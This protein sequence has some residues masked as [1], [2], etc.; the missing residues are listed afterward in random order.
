MNA[1]SGEPIRVLHVDDETDFAELTAAFLER[2]DAAF[3]VETAG[4]ADEAER[5]LAARPFD[6]VVSDYDMPGEN[7]IEFL[8]SVREEHPDLPFVLFTGKGSE[9]VA[10]DAIS[11]GVTDYL[12]KERGTDQ[13]A[14]LAN[15]IAN[16]VEHHR[17]R[18]MVE[19]SE[20]RL[21]EI[22]DTLPDVLYVVDEDGKYL[23]AN[24]VLAEFHD[25]DV[26]EIEGATVEDVLGEDAERFVEDL[27][28]TL[29]ADGVRRI[30]EVTVTDRAGE[31]HVFESRLRPYDPGDGGRAVLGVATDVTE[32]KERE[33]EIERVRERMELA[34]DHTESVIFEVDLDTG[35]VT[36]HGTYDTFFEQSPEVLPTWEDHCE[37]VVHPDDRE[38]FRRLHRR[39]I[40]GET[41][42]EQIEYRTNP[43]TG[44][45]RWISAHL[46]AVAESGGR[47]RALGISRDVTERK[48]REEELRRIERRYGAIFDD[49]NIL[50]GLTD[51]DGTL[52]K[53]NETAMG[54]VDAAR[55]EVVGTPFWETPWFDHSAAARVREGIGRAAA[56]EYVAFE[57]DLVRSGGDPYTVSGI[58]RPVTADDGEV[59]SI[60]A[61]VREITEQRRRER[62]LERTNAVLSTLIDTL[63]VGVLAEDEGRG[64]LAA[65]RRLFDLFD[66]PGAPVVGADCERLAEEVSGTFS[67]PE[68]FRSRIAEVVTEREPVSGEE[69]SLE[70]GR[71]FTR[72]YQPIELGDD[73]GHLWMYRDVTDRTERE[74]RLEALNETTQELMAA[75]THEEV[76]EIGVQAA[77][78]VLNLDANGIHLHD[79]ERGGLVPVAYTEVGGDLVDDPPTFTDGDSIAWGV[80]ERGGAIA[81]DDVDERPDAY[82][83]DSPVRSELFLPLDDYGIL[84]AGSPTPATFDQR[85]LV[86]GKILAGNV[87]TALEQVDRT[88]QLRARERE[89]TRQNDR[90]EEF[91]SVVSHDLRNPLQVA[92][93]RLELAREE[94]ES[95]QLDAVA[96][97]LDR[98]NALVGD[99]LALAREGE[100]VREMESVDLG[101]TCRS[102][103][104]HVETSS[105]TLEVDSS[106]SLRAHRSRLQQLLE[107]LFR[108]AV[109]H[110]STN[111]RSQA[112]EDA[113]E[114]SS[115]N[116]RSQAHEGVHQTSSDEPTRTGGSGDAVEHGGDDVTVT[117][118]A[119]EDG[120]YVADDGPGIPA[121]RREDVFDAGYSTTQGG[122]GFGLSIV[123]GIVDAHGWTVRVVESDGGGARFEI[124]GV[125]GDA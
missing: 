82:N 96:G 74:A 79:D 18:R 71:T 25:A 57:V 69:L 116:P 120:F 59:V 61:S 98:M 107:N 58:F 77:A 42:R 109:E 36:R 81:V 70:D 9:E 84:L 60:V 10:S 100:T 21:R 20:R 85:D 93:G 118:G 49:P 51:T 48:E 37:T 45:R 40:D 68:G 111:P 53:I 46:H 38:A 110:S 90:L 22:V 94:C 23:L 32:R 97:A 12:Q 76:A 39:L 104:R 11:A 92:E 64:V 112:H 33:R 14:V 121:D 41:D 117:V 108:N 86:L 83:P 55:E 35:A 91:A 28:A 13:Y 44:E 34:L 80:Y 24:E 7:G 115:T 3:D 106:R 47:R 113:G 99:L 30:P 16:A 87:A 105:A 72:S 52:L 56:G 88:E 15:R 122:T 75:D 31:A 2:A 101:E 29:D 123:R 17:S 62:E 27:E 67:D 103:W 26:E 78:D 114:H 95:G 43:E 65:S 1:T 73:E 4:S 54:Y 5:R 19:R 125:G 63:P 102:C 6:C 124:T 66:L 119:L 50:V 8:E 89:L